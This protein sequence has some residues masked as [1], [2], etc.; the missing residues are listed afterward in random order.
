M[1]ALGLH[2]DAP[3]VGEACAGG[4]MVSVM[5]GMV[6]MVVVRGDSAWALIGPDKQDWVVEVAK[7]PCNPKFGSL[8]ERPKWKYYGSEQL[9]KQVLLAREATFLT[10]NAD[11]NAAVMI[12]SVLPSLGF[13][14]SA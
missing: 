12:I 5:D 2:S 1:E 11:I 9:R 4:A 14:R 6:G 3:V 10:R 13:L 8:P 7:N